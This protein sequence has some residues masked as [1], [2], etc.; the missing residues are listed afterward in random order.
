LKSA[1]S[2]SVVIALL[3]LSLSANDIKS[4]SPNN[5]QNVWEL[6]G[7]HEGDIMIHPNSPSWKNGLLDATA[8]WPGGIMPYF[9]QEDDFGNSS[10]F[11]I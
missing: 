4:W 8:Q 6:S 9:I 11:F 7:L 1:S 3:S 2:K 5:L 10:S